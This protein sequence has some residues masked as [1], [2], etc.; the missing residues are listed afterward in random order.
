MKNVVG[1]IIMFSWLESLSELPKSPFQYAK[2]TGRLA[3]ELR[4]R[5]MQSF[6]SKMEPL[7]ELKNCFS[8]KK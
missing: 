4:G 3:P 5:D 2:R 7:L 8:E 6:R 1:F